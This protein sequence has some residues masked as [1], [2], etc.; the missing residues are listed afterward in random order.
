MKVLVHYSE[1]ALKKGNRDLF[2]RALKNNI[3]LSLGDL[4][5]IDINLEETI[6]KI[7]QARE[8]KIDSLNLIQEL[9]KDIRAIDFR[10]AFLIDHIDRI[11]EVSNIKSIIDTARE[12]NSLQCSIVVP[13]DLLFNCIT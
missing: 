2:E 5:N 9:I 4:C 11:Q 6:S 8:G 10:I 13:S 7:K 3:R 12:L 1:I